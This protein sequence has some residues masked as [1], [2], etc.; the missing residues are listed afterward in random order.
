M[1][2]N[3]SWIP[4]RSCVPLQTILTLTLGGSSY[5]RL[6]PKVKIKKV[7]LVFPVLIGIVG[8]DA[9]ALKACLS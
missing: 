2:L 6:T 9:L 1:T 7:G 4:G 3:I 8:V 5:Y